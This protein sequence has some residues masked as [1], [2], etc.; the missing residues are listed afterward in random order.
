MTAD[1]RYQANPKIILTE[2]EDGTGVLLSLQSMTYFTLNSTGVVV[3]KELGASSRST[4]EIA[5]SIAATFDV[6]REQANEDVRTL[7]EEMLKE[8][9]VAPC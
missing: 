6:T 1:T 3:W 7:I 4:A 9:L 5:A 8:R 2:L